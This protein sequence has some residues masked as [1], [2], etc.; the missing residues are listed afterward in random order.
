MAKGNIHNSCVF[1]GSQDVTEVP[2]IPSWTHMGRDKDNLICCC[3]AC[4]SIYKDKLIEIGSMKYIRKIYLNKLMMYYHSIAG[5]L[6]KYIKL[7]GN[8]KV[9]DLDV[10]KS[11]LILKSYDQYISD[12]LE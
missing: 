4:K 1:C 11:L 7:Y 2:F 8:Y 6:Y 10:N 5:Y 3:D 9:K 12:N